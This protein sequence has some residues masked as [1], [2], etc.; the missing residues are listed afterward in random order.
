MILSVIGLIVRL[1]ESL[2]RLKLAASFFTEDNVSRG[3][4]RRGVASLG[5]GLAKLLPSDKRCL[6]V[7]PNPGVK[8]CRVAPFTGAKRQ[9]RIAADDS[10]MRPVGR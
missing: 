9:R 2:T 1:I 10:T 7:R 4:Q 5:M 3:G 8:F 6:G